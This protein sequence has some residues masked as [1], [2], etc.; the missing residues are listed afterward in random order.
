MVTVTL[1]RWVWIGFSAI[2]L[3]SGTPALCQESELGRDFRHPFRF[4]QLSDTQTVGASSPDDLIISDGGISRAVVVLASAAGVQEQRGANDLIK[5]IEM[6][7][8]GR[9]ALVMDNQSVDEMLSAD[10][11]R[12]L[13]I[14]GSLAIKD[15][16]ALQKRLN[17]VAKE[18]PTLRADSIVLYRKKNRV[19]IAGNSD[20][21]HYY[22]VAELLRE[23]GCRWFMPG[24]FGEAIPR[25]PTLKIGN[26]DYAYGSPFEVR[27]YWI[28]WNGEQSDRKIFSLRNMMNDV[29]VT[30]GH[31]LGRYT[32]SLINNEHK[33]LFSVPISEDGTANAI[34]N[35]PDVDSMYSQGKDFSLGMEDGIYR[36]TSTI[37]S[38]IQANI[39]DKYFLAP[40]LTDNFM[41]LYNKV[42]A[43]LNKKYPNSKTKIGFLA[44]SNMTIPPQR[45]ISAAAPLVMSL[46]PIDIDPNHGMNDPRSPSKREYRQM[47]RRWSKI[48]GGRLFIRDYDQAM[49]VW[50]DLPNPIAPWFEDDVREYASAGILGANTESRNAIATTFINLYLRGRLLWDPTARTKDILSDFYQRFFGPVAEPMAAYWEAINRAWA[51]TIVT[52]HEYQVIPAIYTPALIAKLRKHLEAAETRMAEIGR[53]GE[54]TPP[55]WEKYRERMKFVRLSFDLID[56]YASGA[57]AA[58]T[59]ADFSK[60]AGLIEQALG[61]R[62]VLGTM[63][64][65]FTTRVIPSMPRSEGAAD[66]PRTMSG[67]AAQYRSLAELTDGTRGTLVQKFPVEWAF[68]RDPRDTGMV[69]GYAGESLD[70]SFWDR[71]KDA[72]SGPDRKNYPTTEWEMLRTD[73]YAQAQGVLHPDGQSYSGY[74]WYRTDIDLDPSVVEKGK[75]IHVMFPGVLNPAWLYVNGAL[76]SYRRFPLLSWMSDYK[77]EWDVDLTDM[78]KPGTNIF[79]VRL[80]N[81][82]HAGGLFRRPFLYE[83]N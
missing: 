65:N 76:V 15:M 47:M 28:S 59:D 10:N 35:N 6:M 16:P 31:A 32:R 64:R 39:F 38:E 14:L 22:A 1:E 70:M 19:Y 2:A 77:F 3:L 41:E 49:L 62:L 25:Q 61:T 4:S 58:A 21:A 63:N 67:E 29:R 51:D 8:G 20:E 43:I 33:S 24:E 48:M 55:D 12:P 57:R 81:L 37:D 26:I 56:Q 45:D 44:Y 53:D 83:A 34:A 82:G 54:P 52:E 13:L 18:N 11:D 36:L 74:L 80:V 5:Y 72:K 40:S 69:S 27:G 71:V 23:W 17:E 68:H 46:A 42:C 78:L 75:R 9:P 7:S 60:A 66:G 79:A 30:G 73:L 50:R